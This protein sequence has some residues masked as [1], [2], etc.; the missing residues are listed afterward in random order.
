[1]VILSTVTG[2]TYADYNGTSMT[3]SHAAGTAALA[4]S[5]N[6]GLLANPTSLKGQPTSSGKVAPAT[7]GKTASAKMLDARAATGAPPEY[8][9]LLLLRPA[10]TPQCQQAA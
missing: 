2:N 10:G 3:T 4:A 5:A 9:L 6:P 8:R 1:M 7:A